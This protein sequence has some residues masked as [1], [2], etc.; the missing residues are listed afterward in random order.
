[1]RAET[2]NQVGTGVDSGHVAPLAVPGSVEVVGHGED[3]IEDG[4]VAGEKAFV[5]HGVDHFGTGSDRGGQEVA[6]T[7]GIEG[8]S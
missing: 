2:F 3:E 6:S 5:V 8:H 7:F 1:M 4:L